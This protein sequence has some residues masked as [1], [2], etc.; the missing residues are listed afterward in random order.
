VIDDSNLHPHRLG[1]G[2]DRL[3]DRIV[4]GIGSAE[5]VN[6]VD[7]NADLRELAPDEFAQ[8]MLAGDLRIHRKH[9]IAPV[10]EELHDSVGGSLRPVRCADHGDRPSVAQKLGNIL[11]AGQRH[12]ILPCS[13]A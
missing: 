9:A 4:G 2:E 6:D 12:P 10:L 13:I 7:R 3:F 11:V 8:H 5:D 1:S